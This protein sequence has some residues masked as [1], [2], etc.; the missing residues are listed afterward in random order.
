MV[1][2]GWTEGKVDGEGEDGVGRRLD[3]RVRLE[4]LALVTRCNGDAGLGRGFEQ[5][6][7][8]RW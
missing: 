7:K 1:E 5:M 2:R 4:L 6:R 3:K 8:A